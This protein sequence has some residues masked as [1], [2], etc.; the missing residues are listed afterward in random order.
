MHQTDLAA[1]VLDLWSVIRADINI[2]D[3]IRPAEGSDRTARFLRSSDALLR[4]GTLWPWMPL[5]CR[6][7]G[8][9]PVQGEIFKAAR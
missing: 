4:A 9:G 7:V 8:H 2:V 3:L 5:F 1:S 6:M